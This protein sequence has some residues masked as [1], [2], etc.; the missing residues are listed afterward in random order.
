M[1]VRRLKVVVAEDEALSRK[2]LVRLLQEAGCVVVNSFAE[3][4]GALDWI[5][6]HREVQ[7]VFL[8]IHMPNLDGLAILKALGGQVPIVLTTAF[9]EHAVE[10]FDAEAV[11][12]LLKPVT[13]ERLGR[14]VERLRS[15]QAGQLPRQGQLGRL[16]LPALGDVL[17]GGHDL[18]GPRCPRQD[19]GGG[20][21]ADPA[22]FAGNRLG[23]AHD[24]PFH[25]LPGA[26][27]DHG[28]VGIPGKGRPVLVDG[29]PPRVGGVPALELVQAQAEDPLGGRVGRDDHAVGVLH[30]EAMQ[31]VP[32]QD[33]VAPFQSHHLHVGGGIGEAG[34]TRSGHGAPGARKGIYKSLNFFIQC[35][36]STAGKCF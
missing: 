32:E 35:Q 2:R 23:Q 8:D 17:E 20:G 12:Y 6:H 26:E 27:G 14:T 9:A 34:L 4:R 3:G 10:A 29:V 5:S 24:H 36:G 15:A 21:D 19:Q 13:D 18:E 28:R 33:L 1:S 7:A 16:A 25:R 11:D 22:G 30:H 31:G